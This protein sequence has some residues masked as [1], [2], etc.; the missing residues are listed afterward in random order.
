MIP[1]A[2]NARAY[3]GGAS[4]FTGQIVGYQTVT[5]TGSTSFTLNSLTGVDVGSPS[6]ETGDVILMCYSYDLGGIGFNPPSSGNPGFYDC[7]DL[8]ENPGGGSRTSVQKMIAQA[9]GPVS[10]TFNT[11]SSRNGVVHFVVLRDAHP[12]LRDFSASGHD[13]IGYPDPAQVGTVDGDLAVVVGSS[14]HA[15]GEDPFTISDLT[16]QIQEQLDTGGTD[17][18]GAVGFKRDPGDDF[19]PAE[20]ARSGS[21]SGDSA[22][23]VSLAVRS[24]SALT[25]TLLPR[26]LFQFVGTGEGLGLYSD[27]GPNEWPHT[28]GG[29]PEGDTAVQLLGKPSIL[30]D[31]SGDFIS[32]DAYKTDLRFLEN[33][34]FTMEAVVRF[35]SV[36]SAQTMISRWTSTTGNRSFLLSL[37]S[38][39]EIDFI[40]AN[41]SNV[42]NRVASGFAPSAG[43]DYYVSVVRD[44]THIG[45]WIDG[46]F[47]ASTATTDTF[48]QGSAPLLLGALNGGGASNLNGN[49]IARLRRGAHY[50]MGVDF[51][52]PTSWATV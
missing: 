22:S 7:S 28:T 49:M 39:G 26:T 37:E 30:F 9:D 10:G 20:W 41:T 31:G 27:E 2:F 24:S 42:V 32:L 51:T 23:S 46:V 15:D 34:E 40:W 4:T 25:D 38:D 6:I 11:T 18:S 8:G 19:N 13:S 33:Y 17:I 48:Q 5:T 12:V 29:D 47:Y 43:V 52:P 14:S 45:I 3:V 36:A 1:F 16:D 21:G 44:S 35:A 50:T